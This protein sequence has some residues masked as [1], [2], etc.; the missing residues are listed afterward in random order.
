MKALVL[1]GG[2][3]TRLRPLTHTFAKQLVPVANRPVLFY[4]LEAIAS[5]GVREVGLVVGAGAPGG[6]GPGGGGGRGGGGGA[7]RARASG[8]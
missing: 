3:G 2:L 5:A 1:A 6:G 4:G 8:R 7:R